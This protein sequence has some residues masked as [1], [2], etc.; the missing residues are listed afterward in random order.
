MPSARG[1]QAPKALGAYELG[2]LDEDHEVRRWFGDLVSRAPKL[3]KRQ[4]TREFA[5]RLDAELKAGHWSWCNALCITLIAQLDI[6]V[7]DYGSLVMTMLI[8]TLGAKERL[9]ARSMLWEAVSAL[10]KRDGSSDEV[11]DILAGLR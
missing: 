1:T 5:D 9:P 4:L 11:E 10:M 2:Y 8:Y 3:T 6:I 7:R